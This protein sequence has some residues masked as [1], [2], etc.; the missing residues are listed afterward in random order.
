MDKKTLSSSVRKRTSAPDSRQSSAAM[1]S[2]GVAV[3]SVVAF[4][5]LAAD[6]PKAVMFVKLFLP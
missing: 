3:I 2:M 6:I 1:G 5:I 4:G